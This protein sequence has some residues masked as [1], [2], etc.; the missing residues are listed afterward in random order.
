MPA[1]VAIADPVSGEMSGFIPQTHVFW[2]T[3]A[4]LCSNTDPRVSAT[5]AARW[6]RIPCMC[7]PGDFRRVTTECTLQGALRRFT[8]PNDILDFDLKAGRSE[9]GIRL[10]FLGATVCF[11]I[12]DSRREAH[13]SKSSKR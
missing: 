4:A 9:W 6:L 3:A 13:L 2:A 8:A 12:A 10:E 11:V 7:F 5:V 1:F